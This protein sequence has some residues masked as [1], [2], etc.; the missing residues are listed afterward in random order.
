[1]H[2]RQSATKKSGALSAVT[3]VMIEVGLSVVA[4]GDRKTMV[5]LER[6]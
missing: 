5:G 6:S 1:M 4:D 3:P 2:E